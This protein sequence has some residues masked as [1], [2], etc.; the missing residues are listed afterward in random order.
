M[1][2]KYAVSAAVVAVMLVSVLA[3]VVV[4]GSDD[5]DV[6]SDYA[7][8]IFLASPEV[9]DTEDV[10]PSELDLRDLGLVTPT[11]DQGSYGTCWAFASI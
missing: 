10:F 8:E 9:S 1:D 3:I 2:S 4:A 11:K 5:R 6:L 7:K